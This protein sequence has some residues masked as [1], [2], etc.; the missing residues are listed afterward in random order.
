MTD[1]RRQFLR[2]YKQMAPQERRKLVL[3]LNGEP[4]TWNPIYIE[5]VN[6]TRMATVMLDAL[7][8]QGTL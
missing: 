8:E 2:I 4:Y 7:K 1:L 5:V 3:E 6:S